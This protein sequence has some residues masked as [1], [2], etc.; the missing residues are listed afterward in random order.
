M[1][2]EFKLPLNG[3]L[4]I[5]FRQFAVVSLLVFSSLGWWFVINNLFLNFFTQLG[6]S[7]FWADVNLVLFYGF[8]AFSALIG[9]SV[10]YK[11][12]NRTLLTAWTIFGILATLA[13][14]FITGIAFALVLS[15]LLGFSIGFGFPA[16]M[17]FLGD[18]TGSDVRGRV[19]GLVVLLTFIT[20]PA[21]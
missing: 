10:S 5:S 9:S 17:A 21:Y 19:V 20:L 15:I 12:K 7:G 1:R 4:K 2:N 16:M 18:S 8:G 13:I 11:F 6:I 14:P 3:Y